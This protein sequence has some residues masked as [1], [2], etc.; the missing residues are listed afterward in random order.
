MKRSSGGREEVNLN[1]LPLILSNQLRKRQNGP[2]LNQCCSSSPT[3]DD[4]IKWKYFP[5]YWFFVRRIHRGPS[6]RPVK[7]IF[8]AFF[9]LR[10][11]KRLSKTSRCRWFETPS[12]SLWP[13]CNGM[14]ASLGLNVRS[15]WK[16]WL[17]DKY[18]NPNCPNQ[19]SDLTDILAW[20]Y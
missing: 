14:F 10:L 9:D 2:C 7:R 12:R 8:H 15:L 16:Y 6:Q 19:C 17:R 4:V 11:N 18:Q 5:R 3:H 13:H 1:T 20:I